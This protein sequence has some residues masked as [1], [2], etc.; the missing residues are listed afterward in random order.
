VIS[1]PPFDPGCV[2]TLRG[3][4]PPRILRLVVTLTVLRP[5]QI[6]FSHSLG[7]L[8]TSI[9]DNELQAQR[10]CRRLQ[11]CDLG[12]DIREGRVRKNPEPGSI[13][14]QLAE[15]LQSFWRQFDL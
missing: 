1:I 8:P 4:T 12:L 10:A 7:P 5:N 14:Y 9:N 15:Q 6:S 3:I 2:K 11:V 13:G